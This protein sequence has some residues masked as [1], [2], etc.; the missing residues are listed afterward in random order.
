M[1]HGV[2]VPDTKGLSPYDESLAQWRQRNGID[3]TKLI[4]LTRISHVRYQHPDLDRITTFLIDFGMVVAK[5]T[6]T[7]AWFRGY[8]TDPY[9]YYACKGERKFLGGVFEVDDYGEMEKASRMKG[10]GG[11]VSL[12]YSPGGGYMLTLH[13]LEGFP[14]S[15]I[16]GQERATKGE[17]PEKIQYNY[18]DEKPR[19]RRFNRFEVGPAAVH[20]LG[21]YGFCSQKFERQ[22]DWYTRTFNFAPSDF[23]Y[24]TDG[25]GKRDIGV[26][27]HIDRGDEAVDH[28]SL[29]ITQNET[30]H[31]HHA[32]FEVHDFDT[33]H[34]GHQWLRKR[35]YESVWGIG[36]HILGSQM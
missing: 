16:Y 31:V 17:F 14:I 7:E 9:V 1:A 2:T 26:F 21:H 18:E 23:L 6:P 36:R 27:M 20:K 33:Q 25:E 22:L 28:H 5:R 4:N 19:I 3:P 34:I 11:I 32:S 30:R 12:D 29:F 24:V 15:L 13:D 8:G 35:G 10:A